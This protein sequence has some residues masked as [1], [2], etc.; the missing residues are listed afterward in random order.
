MSLKNK[1]QQNT[2]KHQSI[3]SCSWL[4]STDHLI[5]GIKNTVSQIFCAAC[6]NK[7]CGI[8]VHCPKLTNS[9]LM[10]FQ[11]QTLNT[12]LGINAWGCAV[13]LMEEKVNSNV[14]LIWWHLMTMHTTISPIVLFYYTIM[15][16]SYCLKCICRCAQR[17]LST[18]FLWHI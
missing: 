1:Q 8:Y 13:H 2:W 15:F 11:L 7:W 10:G 9:W 18:P 4:L 3:S 6:C 12:V 17:Q 14:R 5:L 16:Y